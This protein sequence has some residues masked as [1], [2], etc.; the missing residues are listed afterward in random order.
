MAADEYRRMRVGSSHHRQRPCP[1]A[2]RPIALPPVEPGVPWALLSKG[3]AR[4]SE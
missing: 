4:P 1:V 2:G 3:H